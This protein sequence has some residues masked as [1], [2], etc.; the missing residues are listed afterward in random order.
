MFVLEIIVMLA[1]VA[2]LV[3]S[4]VGGVESAAQATQLNTAAIAL[5][6]LAALLEINRDLAVIVDEVQA[7][8]DEMRARK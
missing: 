5:F 2:A 6:A 8:L 4:F 1:G 7:V 3:W